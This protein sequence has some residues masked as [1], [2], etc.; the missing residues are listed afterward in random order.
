[1]KGVLPLLA[2]LARGVGTR[3]FCPA[4]AA[5]VGPVQNIFSLTVHLYPPKNYLYCIFF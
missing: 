4:L 2:L 1:M 5:L 3:Y